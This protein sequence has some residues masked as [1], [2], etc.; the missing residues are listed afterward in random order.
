M[1]S[2]NHLCAFKNLLIMFYSSQD[3]KNMLDVEILL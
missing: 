1:T 2:K 3:T